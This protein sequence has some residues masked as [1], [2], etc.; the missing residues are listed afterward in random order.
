M[1]YP[2]IIDEWWTITP[3]RAKELLVASAEFVQ[4]RLKWKVDVY[5]ADMAAGRWLDNGESLIFDQDGVLLNGQHRL[6]A[7]IKSGVTL[8]MK[9]T[10]GVPR[11]AAKTMDQGLSRTVGDALRMG[12]TK[13][14]STLVAAARTLHEFRGAVDPLSRSGRRHDEN[15]CLSSQGGIEEFLGRNAGLADFVSLVP[16]HLAKVAPLS[17][18]AAFGFELSLVQSQTDALDFLSGLEGGHPLDDPRSVLRERM[19][20][21]KL[22]VHRRAIRNRVVARARVQQIALMV[23]SWNHWIGGHTANSRSFQLV[24]REHAIPVPLTREEAQGRSQGN[25]NRGTVKP[26]R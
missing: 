17:L 24:Q 25:L 4:R 11:A 12:G 14:A 8:R 1:K 26:R 21:D 13:N 5:A 6:H 10:L 23:M 16:N 9:V 22:A 2:Q 3:Q 15:A 18:L 20:D 19:I 7:I